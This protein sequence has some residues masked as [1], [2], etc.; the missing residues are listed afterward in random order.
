MQKYAQPQALCNVWKQRTCFYWVCAS[1]AS[2]IKPQ[3]QV[4]TNVNWCGDTLANA[5]FHLFYFSNN[6]SFCCKYYFPK[7]E[8]ISFVLSWVKLLWIYGG[9]WKWSRG[10]L[11]IIDFLT[12]MHT[13]DVCQHWEGASQPNTDTSGQKTPRLKHGPAPMLPNWLS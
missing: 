13:R 3:P 6:S 9:L 4:F 8:A 10:L 12:K 7:V 5:S 2:V 11:L 1:S